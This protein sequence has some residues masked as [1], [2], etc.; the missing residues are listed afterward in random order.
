MTRIVP[1]VSGGLDSTLLSV[2]A[3]EEGLEQFPLFINYGQRALDR[4]LAACKHV[5]SALDLPEP[6]V[7]DLSGFG[8]LIQTGLTDPS[9]RVLEDAYTPGRNTLFVLTA[10][11]YACQVGA[12]TISIG[13]LNEETSLFPD[14]TSKFVVE[15]ERMLRLA[16]ARDIRVTAPLSEFFKKDVIKLAES[17]GITATYSC[18]FGAEE[19]CGACIACNEFRFEEA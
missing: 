19:P 18:H 1:L 4:E 17:K 3:K 15:M 13:L 16:V 11:A 5:M 9:K 10:A 7:A 2:L 8:A 14:Q 12:D 6:Q